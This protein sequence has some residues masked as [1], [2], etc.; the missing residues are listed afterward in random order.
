MK[1]SRRFL[2]GIELGTIMLA[3]SMGGATAQDKPQDKLQT[4]AEPVSADEGMADI[5]AG[6]AGHGFG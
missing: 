6:R 4:S 5:H 1:S 2:K 3:A